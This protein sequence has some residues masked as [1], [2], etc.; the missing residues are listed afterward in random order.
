MQNAL[1][2][3]YMNRTQFITVLLLLVLVLVVIVVVMFLK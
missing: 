3:L 1:E 2:E